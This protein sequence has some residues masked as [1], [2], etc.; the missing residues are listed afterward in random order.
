MVELG[1][2]TT[3]LSDGDTTG[4]AADDLVEA[5][6]GS[7]SPS[8][9]GSRGA[10]ML[11]DLGIAMRWIPLR[12]GIARAAIE[13]TT[14]RHRDTMRKLIFR[15]TKAFQGFRDRYDRTLLQKLDLHIPLCL[16]WNLQQMLPGMS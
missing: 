12:R 14:D 15:T 11:V 2:G 1:Q 5:G 16:E 4:A 8:V 13:Q 6:A 3:K 7:D 9:G 10:Q